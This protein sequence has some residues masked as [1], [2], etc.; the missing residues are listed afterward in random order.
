MSD[1]SYYKKHC[2][3]LEKQIEQLKEENRKL[4]KKVAVAH[5]PKCD[6]DL[7][8]CDVCRFGTKKK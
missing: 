5:D 4:K 2:E 7:W 8:I 1:L 3:I 6:G